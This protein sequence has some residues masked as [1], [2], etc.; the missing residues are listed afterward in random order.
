M[1]PTETINSVDYVLIS[2]TSFMDVFNLV[3]E[4]DGIKRT[5]KVIVGGAGVLNIRPYKHLIDYAVFRR[6][7][8]A[9]SSIVSG[10]LLPNIWSRKNDP[11]FSAIYHLGE[12]KKFIG[13]EYPLGVEK[14]VSFVNI[15]GPISFLVKREIA[16]NLALP[17]RK[18]IFLILTGRKQNS[19]EFQ[20]LME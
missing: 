17:T 3:N 20:L 7:E 16:I 18:I 4:L 2:I 9:L 13:N 12:T 5:S 11:E 6:G 14:N 19:T 15:L 8:G 1:F 10:K